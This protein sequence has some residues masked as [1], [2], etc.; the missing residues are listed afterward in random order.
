MFVR[1]KR[2]LHRIDRDSLEISQR[3]AERIRGG[4]IFIR[5]RDPAH[6]PVVCVERD[7]KSV[8]VE[9]I[10]RMF[11]Q[12]LNGARV[13]VAAEANL[14]WDAFIEDILCQRSH[15]ENITFLDLHIFDEARRMADPVRSAPLDGLP[16]GLLTE[17]FARVDRDVEV[18]ALNI[19]KRVDVFLRWIP[20]FFAGQIETDNSVRPEIAGEFRNLQ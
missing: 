16:D 14:E 1:N 15:A 9:D 17:P 4:P 8:S 20:A 3:Q 5:E 11:F 7:A 12:F 2:A 6:Q 18:L 13:D 19:V 10:E